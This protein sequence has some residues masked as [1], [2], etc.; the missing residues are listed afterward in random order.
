[1]EKDVKAVLQRLDRLTQDEAKLTATQI[2]DVVYGLVQ[3]LN[4]I[5]DGEQIYQACHSLGIEYHSFLDGKASLDCVQ[6]ALGMLL[7]PTNQFRV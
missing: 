6:N 1:L 2:L 4:V 7:V 5:T 3:N